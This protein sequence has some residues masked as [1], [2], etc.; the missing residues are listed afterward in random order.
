M[1][2]AYKKKLQPGYLEEVDSSVSR[3]RAQFAAAK[4]QIA[5]DEAARKAV[6]LI[7]PARQTNPYLEHTRFQ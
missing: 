5:R 1:E 6:I 4:A 7:A 2:E 3:L